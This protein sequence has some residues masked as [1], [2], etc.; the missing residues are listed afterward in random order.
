MKKTIIASCVL[1]GTVLCAQAQSNVTLYGV[2]DNGLLWQSSSTSRGSTS[3]GRSVVKMRS[4]MWSGSRFGLKGSEDLGGG[5]KAI[6]TLEAGADSTNGASQWAKGGG[7]FTRQAWVGLS[8]TT[9][10]TLT[11]GRQY[12]AYYTLLSPWSPINNRT[13]HFGAHPGDI[14]GLDTTYR[15]NN[16][17]VYISPTVS[18]LKLGASYALG[19]V[20]G[21]FNAGSTWSVGLQ[22][23]NGPVGL[24][25]AFQ[26]I[27]NSTLGGGEWGKDS[28]TQN[29]NGGTEQLGVSALNNGYK[30]AQGQQRIAVTGGYR[31]SDAFDVSAQYSNVQYVPGT[32]SKFRDTAIFNT[33]GTVLHY[34]PIKSLDLAGGYS[35]THATRANGVSSAAQYQQVTMAQYY[36][37]S[38]RTGVYAVEAYQR[39]NGKTLSDG[40]IVTAT[41]TIGDGFNSSPSSSPSQTA[42]GVGIVHRF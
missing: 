24:A 12:T 36:S 11:A 3:G 25:A 33:V 14:D 35:Y 8:N 19:G 34:R 42:V 2:V 16:S 27:N 22:Y 10:G 26:R 31:F 30:T 18:G 9:Y 6:F 13:G 39:A 23:K 5:T 37:L 15:T 29:G 7:M 38:K 40:K 41:A 17:L 32:G 28:A 4:G 21:R 1:G 20:P